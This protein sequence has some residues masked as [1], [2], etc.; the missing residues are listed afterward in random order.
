MEKVNRKGKS[1]RTKKDQQP[2]RGTKRTAVIT[3]TPD[4]KYKIDVQTGDVSDV[5]M[6]HYLRDLT[7]HFAKVLVDESKDVVGDSLEDQERYLDW[8]IQQSGMN[9]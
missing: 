7:K 3:I 1:Q 2:S 6:L 5:Q 4:A 9:T 8:R